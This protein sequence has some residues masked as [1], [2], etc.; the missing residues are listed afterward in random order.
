MSQ[1]FTR[2][3]AKSAVWAQIEDLSKPD[4]VKVIV[5]VLNDMRSKYYLGEEVAQSQHPIDD[6]REEVANFAVAMEEKL[7]KHDDGKGE[8]GWRK[9]DTFALLQRLREETQELADDL[10]FLRLGDAMEECTDVANF[11]MMIW[12]VLDSAYQEMRKEDED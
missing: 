9:D 5:E 4:Q 11:A 10:R 3:E 8:S 12:D 7:A 2:D 1:P 6:V